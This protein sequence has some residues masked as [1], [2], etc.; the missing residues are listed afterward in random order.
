[1]VSQRLVDWINATLPR[2]ARYAV[3]SERGH[4]VLFLGLARRGV[5]RRDLRYAAELESADYLFVFP[6][7]GRS[8]TV[9]WISGFARLPI[10]HECRVAASSVCAV[11]RLASSPR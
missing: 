4:D 5:L 3:R 2:S 7:P 8:R 11:F 6:A 9:D 1:L 10:V